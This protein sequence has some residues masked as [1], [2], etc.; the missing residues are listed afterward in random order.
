MYTS[1]VTT[2]KDY[3]SYHV[4]ISTHIFR[5]LFA[6]PLHCFIVVYTSIVPT[7]KDYTSYHVIISTHTGYY[8]QRRFIVHLLKD[9]TWNL[10]RVQAFPVIYGMCNIVTLHIYIV[11]QSV[12][13]GTLQSELPILCLVH[14]LLLHCIYSTTYLFKMLDCISYIE[15]YMHMYTTFQEHCYSVC[16]PQSVF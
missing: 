1:I 14:P 4:I 7:P 12:L 8:L 3:T 11:S 2:P 16:V 15:L 9:S 6:A 10:A 5:V 13:F